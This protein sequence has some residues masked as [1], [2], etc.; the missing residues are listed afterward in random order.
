[1]LS[2]HLLKHEPYSD[3]DLFDPR[4]DPEKD[5]ALRTILASPISD[6]HTPPRELATN[7]IQPANS[8]SNN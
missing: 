2:L 4:A 7:N 8:V 3:L 1:M 5:I 6:R